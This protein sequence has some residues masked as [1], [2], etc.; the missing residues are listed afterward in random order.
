M[1]G[2][3]GTELVHDAAC[4]ALL[5]CPTDERDMAAEENRRRTRRFELCPG[6][7]PDRGRACRGSAV[8]SKSCPRPPAS[9]SSATRPGR[10]RSE[11]GRCASRARARRKIT[12][13]RP[14]SRRLARRARP[15]RDRQRK[16]TRRPSGSLHGARR[17]R[18]NTSPVTLTNSRE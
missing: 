1:L 11:L 3:T 16:R 10:T 4:S 17:S 18:A 2:D 5:A 8:P 7:P 13:R 6:C 14:R 9:R 12:Q 15:S